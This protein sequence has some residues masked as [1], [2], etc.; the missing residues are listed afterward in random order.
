MKKTA[1]L[2]SFFLIHSYIFSQSVAFTETKIILTVNGSA[3]TYYDLSANSS[4]GN[5]FQNNGDLGT[6]EEGS[7]SLILQGVEHK[8]SKCSGGDVAGSE[9]KYRIY[10]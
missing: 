4:D 2:L 9:L 5:Q 3:D 10:P 1:L 6:F 7:N 8:V